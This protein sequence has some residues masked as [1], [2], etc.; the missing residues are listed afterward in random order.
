LSQLEQPPIQQ[1]RLAVSLG[2]V[3]WAETETGVGAKCQ[4]P[5]SAKSKIITDFRERRQSGAKK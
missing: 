5:F 1:D 2:P 3:V 4:P